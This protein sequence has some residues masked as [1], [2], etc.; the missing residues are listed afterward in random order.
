MQM[1]MVFLSD[2]YFFFFFVLADVFQIF[3][4]RYGVVCLFVLHEKKIARL[5][6]PCPG[7][8]PALHQPPTPRPPSCR[9]GGRTHSPGNGQPRTSSLMQMLPLSNQDCGLRRMYRATVGTG[10]S[11][12]TGISFSLFPSNIY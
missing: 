9:K 3:C 12:R 6:F 7:S 1:F 10:S 11:L 8:A 4:N 2:F 5:I